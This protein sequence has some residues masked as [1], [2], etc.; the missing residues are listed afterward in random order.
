MYHVDFHDENLFETEG[1]TFQSSIEHVE[2][3]D[4]RMVLFSKQAVYVY[5]LENNRV[6]W[7]EQ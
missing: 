4:K 7:T 5:D 1:E 3:L 2:K 6:L